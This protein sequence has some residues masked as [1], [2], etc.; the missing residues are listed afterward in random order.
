MSPTPR[1][2]PPPKPDE[3]PLAFP[4]SNWFVRRLN[5]DS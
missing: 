1:E 4:L 3:Y 5:G 2:I